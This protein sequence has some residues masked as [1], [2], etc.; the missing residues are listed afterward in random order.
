MFIADTPSWPSLTQLS[1]AGKISFNTI[2]FIG[3]EH[4]RSLTFV[5]PEYIEVAGPRTGMRGWS[6][7]VYARK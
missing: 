6:E 1:S 5:D 4:I 7:S 3:L 2:D